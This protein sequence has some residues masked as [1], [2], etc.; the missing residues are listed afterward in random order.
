[1]HVQNALH[2]DRTIPLMESMFAEI[3]SEMPR[4]RERWGAP[5]ESTFNTYKK[6]LREAL[7]KKPEMVKLNFMDAFGMSRAEVDELFTV[8]TKYTE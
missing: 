3:E 2:P 1:M 6:R 7:L 8:E 4:Q 5:S